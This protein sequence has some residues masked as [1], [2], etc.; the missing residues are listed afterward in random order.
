[1]QLVFTIHFCFLCFTC[2]SFGNT[3]P[4]DLLI[5]PVDMAG[6]EDNL[7]LSGCEEST[8]YRINFAH[9]F[10]VGQRAVCHNEAQAG[11]A[12]GG[13]LDV[14]CSANSLNDF[15][16]DFGIIVI[17]SFLLKNLI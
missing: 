3:Q 2:G 4:D 1:M 9:P 8:F 15:F 12:V 10:V 16:C 6:T 11:G 17:H 5:D 13:R 14:L 7:I